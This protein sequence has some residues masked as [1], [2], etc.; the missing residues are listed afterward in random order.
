MG[1]MSRRKG[2]TYELEVVHYLRAQGWDGAEKSNRT[3]WEPDRGD[4]D[5]L[6]GVIVECKNH[7]AMTLS[8]WVDQLDASILRTNANV[9]LVIHK[10]KGIVD[11]GR[12]YATMPVDVAAR[13]LRE[14]GY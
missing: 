13:L 10:R 11:V 8:T 12:H 5:G 3:G 7:A 4:I 2:A 6:V 1:S 14:A 9:G